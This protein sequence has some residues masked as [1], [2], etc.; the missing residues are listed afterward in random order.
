MEIGAVLP[1]AVGVAE[2]RIKKILYA[3]DNSSYGFIFL[4]RFFI[5]DRRGYLPP[6]KKAAKTP[7]GLGY[8]YDFVYRSPCAQVR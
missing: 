5:H 7:H 3:A 8:Y 2:A 4:S 1:G 6:F